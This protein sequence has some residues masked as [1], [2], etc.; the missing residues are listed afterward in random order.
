MQLFQLQFVPFKL[1]STLFAHNSSCI[2]INSLQKILSECFMNLLVVH[3]L[4]LLF[5]SSHAWQI[6]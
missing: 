1:L 3:L 5:I 2:L 6:G 4:F